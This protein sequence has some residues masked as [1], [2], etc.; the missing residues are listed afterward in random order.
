MTR[1]PFFKNAETEMVL[2]RPALAANVIGK[3]LTELCVINSWLCLLQVISS[4][5]LHLAWKCAEMLWSVC[6]FTVKTLDVLC[7]REK[8]DCLEMPSDIS[9]S[10]WN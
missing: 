6:R 4:L 7:V 3:I 2:S 10:T 8:L 9:I 1:N 5:L